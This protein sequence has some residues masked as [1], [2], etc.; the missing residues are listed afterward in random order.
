M[1]LVG[2]KTKLL[3]FNIKKSHIQTTVELAANPVNV[4][5]NIDPSYEASHVGVIRS[6]HGNMAH[7]SER[8]SAHRKS[9]YAVLHGG[10]ARG[11]RANLQPLS[12]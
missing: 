4:D 2:S 3:V 5:Q 8:L 11:H 9:V 7:I 1:Q 12:G 6:V 10:L